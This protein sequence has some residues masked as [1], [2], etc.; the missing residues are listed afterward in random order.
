MI[1]L[2]EWH[3]CYEMV[4]KKALTSYF[5]I[6]V[7]RTF[8]SQDS[9]PGEATYSMIGYDNDLDFNY[10][11]DGMDMREFQC[12]LLG[13]GD[14]FACIGVLLHCPVAMT[15]GA[16]LSGVL[17]YKVVEELLGIITPPFQTTWDRVL[18]RSRKPIRP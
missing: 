6:E 1:R 16:G 2:H 15:P 9:I 8:I 13:S 17:T 3:R 7:R 10:S 11:A 14:C 5:E 18:R 4:V 12:Y